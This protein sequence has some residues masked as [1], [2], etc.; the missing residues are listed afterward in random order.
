ME[1]TMIYEDGGCGVERNDRAKKLRLRNVVR[2]ADTR[3]STDSSGLLSYGMAT[4]G[5]DGS[6]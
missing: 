1:E 6:I 3:G 2:W 4:C 5:W